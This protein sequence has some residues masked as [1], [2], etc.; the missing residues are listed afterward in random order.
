M[1]KLQTGLH[2]FLCSS[3]KSASEESMMKILM[4]YCNTQ[5]GRIRLLQFY[6]SNSKISLLD[7]QKPMMNTRFN[8]VLR[9]KLAAIGL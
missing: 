8:L 5:L 7:R 1:S 4:A 3:T 2:H 9:W 6:L